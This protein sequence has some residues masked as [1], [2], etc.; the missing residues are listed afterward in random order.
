M[1][2]P[3]PLAAQAPASI[4]AT[5]KE[6]SLGACARC[7][8]FTCV[9]CPASAERCVRCEDEAFTQTSAVRLV[10]G[11]A[12]LLMALAALGWVGSGLWLF[13]ELQDSKAW[14]WESSH[15]LPFIG[16]G[17]SSL[18]FA[19]GLQMRRLRSY[20][21]AVLASIVTLVVL[22]PVG[23]LGLVFGG[24]ALLTLSR[25]TVRAGFRLQERR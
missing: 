8:V 20:P 9:L 7:G 18:V 23:G 24:A 17:I 2:S 4:C 1:A 12:F 3:P 19:G 13:V 15:L 25:D 22:F 16:F 21:L 14:R 11:P 10:G 6:P 5:H